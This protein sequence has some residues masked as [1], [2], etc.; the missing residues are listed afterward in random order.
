MLLSLNSLVCRNLLDGSSL[1]DRCFLDYRGLLLL[2]LRS[3][4]INNGLINWLWFCLSALS[5]LLAISLCCNL[6]GLNLLGFVLIIMS[7]IDLNSDSFVVILVLLVM[8]FS[9]LSY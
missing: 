3:S 1:V 5:L 7:Q 6:L 8:G 2:V 4:L 9:L